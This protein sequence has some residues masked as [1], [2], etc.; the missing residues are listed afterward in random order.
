MAD[1]EFEEEPTYAPVASQVA[2]KPVSLIDTMVEKKVAKD[3]A[4]ASKILTTVTAVCFGLAF[5]TVIWV[6][7]HNANVRKENQR[8]DRINAGLPPE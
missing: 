8:I 6:Q 2:N 5:L 7:I 4:H 1:V 3:E